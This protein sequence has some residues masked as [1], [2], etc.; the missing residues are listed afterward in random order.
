VGAVFEYGPIV[1]DEAEVISFAKR[2]DP[3]TMHVDPV[4]AAAGPFHG[5]IASGWHTASMMMRPFVDRYLSSVASLAS[6]GVDEL[7]W[8]RPVRP[9][10][11]LMVRVTTTEAR[12]S[13]SKPDRGII[14]TTIEGV[15]QD[16][17]VVCS[18]KA[19]T[20]MARRS[21]AEDCVT[22]P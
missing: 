15:N 9:G 18:M 4:V 20:M 22:A 8:R 17:I 16:G 2:Y 19:M 5:L 7:R 14:F 3:Q 12:A 13:R 6:P 11:W 1:V 10:D 21:R